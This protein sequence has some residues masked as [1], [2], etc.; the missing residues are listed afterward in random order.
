MKKSL[1]LVE[2]KT[3]TGKLFDKVST[4]F[5]NNWKNKN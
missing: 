4:K 5:K 3:A 2:M 1:Q